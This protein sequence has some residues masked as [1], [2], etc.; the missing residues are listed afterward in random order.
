MSTGKKAS[1]HELNDLHALVAREL[2]RKIKAGEATS[3]DF[4]AAIKFLKDNGIEAQVMPDNPLG[5]L[6][7]AITEGLPF[8][9]TDGPSH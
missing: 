2:A 6:G 5:Q 1:S 8:A 9:G 7:V 3:A 4:S